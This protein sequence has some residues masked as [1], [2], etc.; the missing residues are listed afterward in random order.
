MKRYHPLE[1]FTPYSDN[2]AAVDSTLTSQAIQQ[3]LRLA[4][5]FVNSF[6]SGLF[7]PHALSYFA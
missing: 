2:Q 4:A 3:P 7:Y 1:L 6:Q 5:S